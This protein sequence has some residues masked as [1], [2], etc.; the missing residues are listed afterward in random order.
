MDFTGLVKAIADIHNSTRG[1]A[2]ASVNKMLTMRNWLIGMYLVEYEQNGEDRA[3][4][5]S[6]LLR[7]LSEKL[8]QAGTRGFSPTNLRLSRKFYLEYQQL[9]PLFEIQINAIGHEVTDQLTGEALFPKKLPMVSTKPVHLSIQ[10]LPTAELCNNIDNQSVID[11]SVAPEK[12]LKHYS[13]THFVELM[14]IDD[15]L[16][17]AFYEIEGING[18][19]SV[20]HKG[21]LL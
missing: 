4:Y 3:K 11:G 5:G 16:K 19:W 17:R 8:F 18:C 14:R 20:P 15:P 10:Q 21:K 6:D 12:L 7:S 2:A 13:F 9:G 1:A